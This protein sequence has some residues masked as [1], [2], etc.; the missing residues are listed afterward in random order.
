MEQLLKLP[1]CTT[2]K[3]TS[4]R[5]VYDK[6]DV[7]IKGLTSLGIKSERYVNFLI[8]VIMTI[9]LP[10]KFCLHFACDIN[11]EV[12]EIKELMDLVKRE[13][14]AREA[15]ELVKL[16]SLQPPAQN[17]TSSQSSASTFLT[18]GSSIKCVHCSECHYFAP[19]SKFK[20][21]QELM[22]YCLD[23]DDTLTVLIESTIS[24][25]ANKCILQDLSLS[26]TPRQLIGDPT[27]KPYLQPIPPV[28]PRSN[29]QL[30][31]RMPMP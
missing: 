16:S 23:L 31:C 15:S 9:K 6:I 4:L 28:L 27:V 25:S 10:Q 24:P 8:T 5:L 30:F 12:W 13:V 2:E 14:K 1:A 22:E 11:K 19:C 29:K 20:T 21:L 17:Q 18:S 7:N 26:T 3:S